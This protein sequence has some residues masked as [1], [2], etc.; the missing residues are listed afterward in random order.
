MIFT[1]ITPITPINNLSEIDGLNKNFRN[2]E[3]SEQ[4]PFK[5]IFTQAL[6]DYKT[7]EEQVNR[8]IYAV[9]TGTTDDLHNLMI[10]MEKSE[11]ALELFVQLRN[12]ALDAYKELMNVNM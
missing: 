7:A 3:T 6:D 9:A 12:K 8:D 4:S 11:M 2:D 10:N 5:N 1:Q